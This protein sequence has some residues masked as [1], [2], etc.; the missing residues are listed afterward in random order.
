MLPL[1]ALLVVAGLVM[2]DLSSIGP[3][4][5]PRAPNLRAL[6][7]GS[8]VTVRG[9]SGAVAI[10]LSHV[11]KTGDLA[12]NQGTLLALVPNLDLSVFAKVGETFYLGHSVLSGA[13]LG[14]TS[15]E[16]VNVQS[17][18]ASVFVNQPL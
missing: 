5:P 9:V 13:S 7:V 3:P 1:L 15:D 17:I 14:F 10:H 2:A 4:A 18:P 11:I 12:A 6:P 8:L 16:I